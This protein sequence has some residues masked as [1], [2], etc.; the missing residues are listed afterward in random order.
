MTTYFE[1][2]DSQDLSSFPDILPVYTAN[3]KIDLQ[4]NQMPPSLP[5][6][7]NFANKRPATSSPKVNPPS[8]T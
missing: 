8:R 4:P 3:Q 2:L 7:N 1:K 5:A 6:S